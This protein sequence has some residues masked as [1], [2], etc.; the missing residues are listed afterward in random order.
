MGRAY[1]NWLPP[2][3]KLVPVTKGLPPA[4]LP[5]SHS[6]KREPYAAPT[7]CTHGR[8]RNQAG[9]LCRDARSGEASAERRKQRRSGCKVSERVLGA[10]TPR[11][12]REGGGKER[13]RRRVGALTS[14]RR[15]RAAMRRT[16]TTSQMGQ[17]GSPRAR[18][19]R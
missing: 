2:S 3:A 9:G 14:R 18:G 12:R 10:H 19:A 5:M 16:R 7:L 15:G 4:R 1:L 13:R 11:G 6:A 8:W 17:Q